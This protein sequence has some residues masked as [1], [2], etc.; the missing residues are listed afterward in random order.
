MS[1]RKYI[2]TL[3][4]EFKVKNFKSK[5]RMHNVEIKTT[6]LFSPVLV[7]YFD[8]NKMQEIQELKEV[9]RIEIAP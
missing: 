3:H 6:L 7:V 1:K 9:K 4:K 5:L 2:I 8:P